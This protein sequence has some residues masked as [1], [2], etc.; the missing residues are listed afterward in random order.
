MTTA[1]TQRFTRRQVLGGALAAAGASA[2]A[3]CVP[4]PPQR[5][6]RR[7]V[8]VI[9]TGFGGS[10]TARRL[11]EAGVEVTLVERGRR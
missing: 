7:R 5:S 2:A 1:V 9:G 3:A 11:A 6:V 8:V 10:V 4:E